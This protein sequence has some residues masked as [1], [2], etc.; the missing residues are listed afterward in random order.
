MNSELLNYGLE[1]IGA[2]AIGFITFK[3]IKWLWDRK[4]Q[5]TFKNPLKTY[6]RKE[7]INY[8][9]EIQNER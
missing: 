5:V 8:L 3:G 1:I 9:K 2:F 6:I 4:P 7:V